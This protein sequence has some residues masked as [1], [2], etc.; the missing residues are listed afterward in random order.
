MSRRIVI[1]LSFITAI[2]ASY[3]AGTYSTKIDATD[4]ITDEV[5]LEVMDDLMENH[6]L[7]PTREMLLAGAVDG[8][9]GSLND[10]FTTYFD[11]EERAS[12]EASFGES[13]VGIGVTVEF[14]EKLIV[15]KAVSKDGPADTAGIR[16]NDII[17]EVDGEDIINLPFYESIGMIIGDVDT[18]VSIGVIRNG[19]DGVIYLTM[20]RKVI[21]NATVI[22]DSFI[23]DE[24]LIGYIKVT[25]FGDETLNL[26][27]S[28]LADLETDGITGL[29]IDLRDNGGGHLYTVQNMLNQFLIDDGT[30]MFSTQHYSQGE[31]ITTEYNSNRPEKRHYEIVT[32]V[33]ENSA[34]AS[35]VFSS[36]MQEHGGYTVLG[37]T[38][39]GKGTMQTDM[40][41]LATIGDKLH[42]TIGKWF[43]TD[44]GWV[45]YDGGT[46]GVIPDVVVEKTDIE[47]AY[48]VFLFEEEG[49]I[50]YDTVDL[51]VANIQIVLNMMGYDVRTDG[52]FDSFTR[53][54]ILD[55]QNTNGLTESG[56][57]DGD[58]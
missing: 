45:H 47:K 49:D 54:A 40:S 1:I 51:R 46:D 12:Y 13:Y 48:K 7:Q 15:V 27:L 5:F 33:N 37:T 31:L 20:T 56:N 38:T 3:F 26:F 44:G 53:T 4:E 50:M 57:L 41:I 18:E 22:V 35:E 24:E 52:Y 10:P 16:V 19:V 23:R 34:S 36:A 11:L 21:P 9:I 2:A 28:A 30:P 6:Y 55:I 17:A 32:L 43:T 14:L 39:Y 58:T 8:M 42:I 25:T 29:I